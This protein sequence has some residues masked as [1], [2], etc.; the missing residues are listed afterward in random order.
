MEKTMETYGLL[1]RKLGHS[2]SPQIHK[3]LKGYDYALYER[4]PE[5]VGE[6]LQSGSFD[7]INVT[8][9]LF[10]K[11]PKIVFGIPFVN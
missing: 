2:F 6:F 8:I 10:I 11:S 9:P 7:G 4:E 3:A 5:D 1:G